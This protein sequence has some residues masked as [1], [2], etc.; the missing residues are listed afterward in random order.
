MPSTR[1]KWFTVEISADPFVVPI[2]ASCETDATHR[3]IRLAR[4]MGCQPNL[5]ITKV[6]LFRQ[7]DA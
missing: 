5:K 7:E 4:E 3:A 6:I 2:R 1:L